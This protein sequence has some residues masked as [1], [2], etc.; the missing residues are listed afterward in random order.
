[1]L[2]LKVSSSAFSTN[3]LRGSSG[4]SF[5]TFTIM[6]AV[7]IIKLA[8]EIFS[9]VRKFKP[10][11]VYL[12]TLKA[13]IVGS[14]ICKFLRVPTVQHVQD[15]MS[16]NEFNKFALYIIKAFLAL[17]NK[18]ITVSKLVQRSVINLGI[19]EK[20]VTMIYN[21]IDIGKVQSANRNGIHDFKER[22]N[23]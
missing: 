16:P 3:M 2:P 13:G 17:N 19:P 23:I 7:Y 12:N 11:V 4:L 6:N 9:A 1:M 14:L 10:D 21:G 8:S 15:F 22:Y 5:I 18:I 20:R